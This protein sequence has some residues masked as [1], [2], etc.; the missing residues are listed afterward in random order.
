MKSYLWKQMTSFWTLANLA[1]QMN[2]I[3]IWNINF[4][5]ICPQI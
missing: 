3:H 5:H 4:I 2:E 1:L